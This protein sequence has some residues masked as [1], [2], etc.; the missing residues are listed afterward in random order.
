MTLASSGTLEARLRHVRDV[1]RNASLDALVVTHLPNLFYLT[2]FSGT[3][4]IGVVMPDA[5]GFITDFRYLSAVSA[6]QA[7]RSSNCR[8]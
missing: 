8:N 4:A 5:V 1:V 3:S 2:N 6:L 7:H